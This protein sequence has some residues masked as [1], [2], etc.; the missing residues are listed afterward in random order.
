MKNI[1]LL[2]KS[3]IKRNRMG[4]L[5]SVFSG[6]VLSLLIYLMGQFVGSV[7]LSK[8]EIGVMDYDKSILSTDFKSYLSEEAGL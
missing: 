2:V 6:V 3:N 8:I 4:I 1:I 5:L 7:A